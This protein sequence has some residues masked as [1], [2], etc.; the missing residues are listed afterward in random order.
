MLDITG[1]ENGVGGSGD[2]AS[3]LLLSSSRRGSDGGCGE[4]DGGD[5]FAFSP[6]SSFVKFGSE[7][8][9]TETPKEE[10]ESPL[11]CFCVVVVKGVVKSGAGIVVV[12]AVVVVMVV[13]EKEGEKEDVAVKDGEEEGGKENEDTGVDGE[14]KRMEDD[15][16]D[17]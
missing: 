2:G 4:G 14:G 17:E 12:L 5:S 11:S 1:D 10:R 3:T 16:E 8:K 9:S 13:V 7:G 6:I 15:V